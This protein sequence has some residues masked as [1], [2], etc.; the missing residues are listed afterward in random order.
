MSSRFFGESTVLEE[1]RACHAV[2]ASS[3]NWPGGPSLFAS[4]KLQGAQSPTT[5]LPV[6]ECYG[7][8]VKWNA[9]TKRS[10]P[11]CATQLADS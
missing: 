6:P 2:L 5:A 3:K 11:E 4:S 7:P 9:A 8:T 1:K 10:K